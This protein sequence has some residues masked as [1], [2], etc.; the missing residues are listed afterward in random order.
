MEVKQCN[1]LREYNRLDK[2]IEKFF[3]SICKNRDFN[4]CFWGYVYNR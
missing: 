3:I 4:Q 1:E 2:E